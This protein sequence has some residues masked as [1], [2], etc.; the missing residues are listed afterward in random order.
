MNKLFVVALATVVALV[1]PAATITA[2]RAATTPLSPS[3]SPSSWM[4]GPSP[5]PLP[6]PTIY[7]ATKTN[8]QITG[9]TPT[10]NWTPLVHTSG[11]S[12][13]PGAPASQSP[14]A[15]P[16][17]QIDPPGLGA[18][19]FYK[20]ETTRLN[21][22]T[23][24]SV[25]VA[26]GNLVLEADDL[27]VKG[28]GLNL[29]V[30]RVYN[31]L[32][33][34]SGDFGNGW[35]MTTGRDVGLQLGSG[36]ITF[37]GPGGYQALFTGNGPTYT[38]P[39]GIDADLTKNGDGTFT[40]KFHQSSETLN[41][42][43]GGFLTT[44]KDRN[45]NTLSFFYDSNNALSSIRDTQGR[46]T[47]FGYTVMGSCGVPGTGLITSMTD[48]SGR[49]FKYD[50]D[51]SCNLTNY[52]DPSTNPGY[53]YSYTNGDLTQTIDGR[54][55]KTSFSYDS[56][57]RAKMVTRA[58]NDQT[59]YTTTYTYNT[60]ATGCPSPP[61]GDT[62][63]GNTLSSDPNAHVTTYC[64]N[65]NGL[66]DAIKDAAGNATT[67]K[68]T[69]DYNVQT[70]TN[71][72]LQQLNF[73][74]ST[75]G[76][77]NLVQAQGPTGEA[78]YLT[79]NGSQPYQPDSI[80]DPQGNCNALDYDAAGNLTD[81]YAGLSGGSGN[82]CGGQTGGSHQQNKYQGDPGVTCGAKQGELCSS[83]DANGNQ[84]SYGYD[85]NG[86]L[87][88][89]THPRPLPAESFT[90]DSLSRVHTHTDGKS[91]TTTSSYDAL[92][93]VVKLTYQ[94]GSTIIY[95]PDADGNIT[96][97]QDNTGTTAYVYDQLNRETQQTLPSGAIST[98]S[99]DGVGNLTQLVDA[100]G[101]VGYHYNQVNLVDTLTEPS[102][103]KTTFD[104]DPSYQ[105][106]HTNYPNGVVMT[107]SYDA[108]ERLTSIVATKGST[109]LTGYSY[110]YTLNG[111]DT[112]LRQTVT[113]Q[114]RGQTTTYNYDSQNRLT[115]ATTAGGS[116]YAYAY[117]ANG[118]R[119]SQTI[120]GSQT[121]YA[122]NAA[123]EL[124]WSYAGASNAGCSLPPT[125]ATTYTFDGNGNETGDS[126]G[127]SFSYNAKNQTTSITP[128]G[129]S[130]LS[131]SY[132]GA[133][134]DERVTAGSD[135]FAY[136]ELGLAIERTN[137]TTFTRDNKGV[138]IDERQNSAGGVEGTPYYY[139]FDG[140]GSVVGLTDGTGNLV[141]TYQYDP[142][143]NVIGST[144][145]TAN[146]WAFGSGFGDA[147]TGLTKFG[148]RYYAPNLGDWTQQDLTKLGGGGYVYAQDNPVDLVDPSGTF[149]WSS[150]GYFTAAF[151]V[152]AVIGY[153]VFQLA[154]IAV[155]VVAA[156]EAFPVEA[157]GGVGA[158][159]S[160]AVG[161][162]LDYYLI[163]QG[164]QSW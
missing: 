76:K 98:F 95:Q 22:R 152:T 123:N 129:G 153:Y 130:A 92:D 126:A 147:A 144:G 71:A 154:L 112:S 146:P 164:V 151:F 40:L 101:T 44:D 125:G 155:A 117:D 4:M 49:V 66:V 157:V 25:N 120:N 128:A 5:S 27:Q 108:S 127:A 148:A 63:V 119:L 149:S 97:L 100:G 33:S 64:Y 50:Y 55:E 59:S 1:L 31:N 21:D 36:Q 12:P 16:G 104:Y 84:T 43:S 162:W 2:A 34:S 72:S 61:P 58:L 37:T 89:I 114:V 91:Q 32:S 141:N 138:L 13:V 115:S 150:I 78:T 160:I 135:A 75:D 139:L 82:N 26:N 99:Y 159:A 23:L 142:F 15:P 107:Q 19:S 85:S 163:N 8:Q 80:T 79:Y 90:V 145:A 102:G 83:I 70:F 77:N 38:S 110:T 156:P 42:T 69:S 143:G 24:L 11:A 96:G 111:K 109:E 74:Y 62:I 133:S 121:S 93:R 94:D 52:A 140:L 14:Q 65:S 132:T 18:R 7:D 87:T 39:P 134:Q 60:G 158:V 20:L 35:L 54:N 88:S 47:T 41:F 57:H 56:S 51:S 46:V 45:G 67:S 9:G 53:T 30:S 161:I 131:M 106:L 17:T 124:C 6:A 136:N 81:S 68:Y 28:T 122:Y 3:P 10:G 113:D 29:D 48:S 105:R 103:A 137:H 73:T 86:N 116:T 118:N